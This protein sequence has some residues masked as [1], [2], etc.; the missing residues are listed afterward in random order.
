[1]FRLFTWVLSL[2]IVPNLTPSKRVDF[3]DK[4]LRRELSKLGEFDLSEWKETAMPESLSVQGKFFFIPGRTDH[5]ERYVYIGRVNTCR[6][7][8]CSAPVDPINF[9]ASEYFDYFIVFDSVLSV[10]K[11]KIHDYQASHGHEVTNKGWLKQFQGYDGRQS[12]TVGKSID[13]ISGATISVNG[14]TADIREKTQ[15]LKKIVREKN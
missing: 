1:M 11:V 10:Q 14:I 13:A 3:E 6:Q 8:G 2:L 5:P 12:L 9:E 15:L 4:L 7:G